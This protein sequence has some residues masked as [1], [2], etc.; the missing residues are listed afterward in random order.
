M[1]NVL[2]Y[3][4][5]LPLVTFKV[6]VNDAALFP[7][8]PNPMHKSTLKSVPLQSMGLTPR[9]TGRHLSLSLLFQPQNQCEISTLCCRMGGDT[10][11]HVQ[12]DFG[13]PLSSDYSVLAPTDL[14]MVEVRK[15]LQ[16]EW[17]CLSGR[18]E[19]QWWWWWWWW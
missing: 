1:K 7:I 15:G 2:Q 19:P 6:L 10:S 16:R 8:G 12:S 11:R 5:H 4:G 3:I 17:L 14:E 18:P 13:E 9:K